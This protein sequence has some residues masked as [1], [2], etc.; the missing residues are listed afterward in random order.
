MKQNSFKI[1]DNISMPTKGGRNRNSSPLIDTF[2]VMRVGQ[3][4][5]VDDV[6]E[7]DR[8]AQ[9]SYNYSTGK[10]TKFSSR[11]MFTRKGKAYV[12]IWRIQ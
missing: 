12:R 2:K 8:I 9:A 10:T 4:F 7:G 3:S 11:T 5:R 6:K 1:E